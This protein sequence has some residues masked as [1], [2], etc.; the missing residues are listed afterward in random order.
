MDVSKY[1]K[2]FPILNSDDSPV[3]L[4]SACMTLR[5]KAV[6]DAITDYYT[7]YPACGGRSVHKLSW[8]VTEN[9]EMARDS[10]RRFMGA[11][12]SSE[13]VFTKNATESMNIVA[14]GLSLNKGDEVLTSDKE[15]NANVVPWHHLAKYKGIKYNV[16]PAKDNYFFD[17]E[18]L[19]ESLSSKTKLFSFVHTSNLDG[20]SN[21]AKE[22]VEICH[23][24][25]VKVMMDTAQ[26]A[27]HQEV[28]VVDLDVD[29]AA[30]SAHKFCGPSGMGAL[31][32]KFD[33]LK[34]LI[35]TYVGGSTVVNSTY[36]D[37]K[38]L[39][40]PS[41]FEAGL[42]NYAGAIGSGA[43][44]EYIM[45]IG[46]ENIHKHENKLNKLMT[47]ELSDVESLNLVGPSDVNQRGGIFSFNL[48]GWDPTEVAMHLD[49]EYNIAIRSGM[50][51]VH[52][53]FNSR[54]IEGTARASVYLYNN[55]EDVLSFTNAIKESIDNR[56]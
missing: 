26:S 16:L 39:P 42:Q 24:K 43:A 31:Y 51:C 36:K 9:F 10:L 20:H 28:N 52:S 35:P 53:W 55:E 12:S 8:Q 6:I 37:Y 34:D 19:K 3:Y 13:I 45:N 18:A 49:E 47:K 32:G 4:D 15:H 50:H 2:D 14:N 25:G 22:I 48:D 38:L 41:C 30:V 40:P 46:R 27:P 44:A 56:K 54:G 23:D 21:P 33:E 5:P 7:N 1:R 11:E 29:F 17:V